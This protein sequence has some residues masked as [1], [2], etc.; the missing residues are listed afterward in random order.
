MRDTF[1]RLQK[2]YD[3]T[4]VDA[5]RSPGEINRELQERIERVLAGR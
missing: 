4:I 5:E 2:T 3:F 1:R